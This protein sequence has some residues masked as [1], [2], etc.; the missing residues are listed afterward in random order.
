MQS[1]VHKLDRT[2][3]DR[4]RE[5]VTALT[6]TRKQQAAFLERV[7]KRTHATAERALLRER[8]FRRLQD[9]RASGRPIIV[10]PWTGE[11]GFELL[12]WI[13]FVRWAIERF[14]LSPERITIMSRGGTQSWY[15]LAGVRYVDV[16]ERRTPEALRLRMAEQKKQRTV[17]LFDRR[18]IRELSADLGGQ[19]GVLHPS[20]M[21]S[22]LMPYWKQKVGIEWVE[23]FSRFE[24]LQPP[25]LP[26]L[27]LPD[28]FTAVRFYYSDCFPDTE[29]NQEVVRTVIG[30]LARNGNVVVLGSGAGVDEHRDAMVADTP[31][32]IQVVDHMSCPERN[33][34]V[35][36][37][38]IARASAFVGTYGGFSYLAP[39]CGVNTV[40]LYSLDNFYEYHLDFARQ[41]FARVGGG[42]L[43]VVDTAV[44]DLV[45]QIGF[46][47]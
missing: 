27:P 31:G 11:V 13:P 1:R 47:R 33:L 5:T 22:L 42:S 19:A 36:T 41:L 10:G 45:A 21:Y 29:A 16:L 17:R 40:A 24:R 30:G 25:S 28:T 44:R 43:T 8:V 46:S 20:L 26:D 18:L 14:H 3:L 9:L 35:Q 37:A 4:H 39:L 23:Q 38:V 2:M 12:Y 34:E 15:G 7:L 32:R 6:V